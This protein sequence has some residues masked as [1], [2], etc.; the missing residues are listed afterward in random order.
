[1]KKVGTIFIPVKNMTNTL[2]KNLKEYCSAFIISLS[3]ILVEWAIKVVSATTWVSEITSIQFSNHSHRKDIRLKVKVKIFG[4]YE[5]S[6]TAY[7]Y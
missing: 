5:Y 4:I 1:M 3:G 7:R 6:K 2:F